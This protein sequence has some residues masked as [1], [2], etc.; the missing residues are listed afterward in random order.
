MVAQKPQN[1]NGISNG[2]S[3][4]ITEAELLLLNSKSNNK[5]FRA[6]DKDTPDMVCL[7]HLRWNF[8]YQRPQHLLTRCAA[9][10]RVFFI[11]EP[12]FIT[13]GSSRVE[14]TKDK[15][16]VWVVV[17]YLPKKCQFQYQ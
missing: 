1:T 6:T 2:K 10:R 5:N 15:S 17:P 8:V 13:E 12:I 3:Q 4:N 14:V 7:S 11:E 9:G 16:G